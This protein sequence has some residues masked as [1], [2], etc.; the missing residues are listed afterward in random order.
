M[1]WPPHSLSPEAKRS[2][3]SHNRAT[4]TSV[5]AMCR[6]QISIQEL[7]IEAAVPNS[8]QAVL[9]EIVLDPVVLDMHTANEV[10]DELPMVRTESLL[11]ADESAC[12]GS[13]CQRRNPS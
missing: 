3:K 6:Q 5:T 2:R 13:T 11:V 12:A 7:A 8:H 9:Q 1:T 4:P 10:L